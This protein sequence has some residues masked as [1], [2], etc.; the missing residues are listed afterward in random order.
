MST[1]DRDI[2]EWF[3]RWW[4]PWWSPWW[5]QAAEEEQLEEISSESLKK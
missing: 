1:R 5:G 2:D 3:R 4:T